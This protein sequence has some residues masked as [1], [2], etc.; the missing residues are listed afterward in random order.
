MGE[1]VA[2]AVYLFR[3]LDALHG[4]HGYAHSAAFAVLGIDD[5]LSFK[6]HNISVIGLIFF[7][8]VLFFDACKVTNKKH[9]ITTF[10]EKYFTHCFMRL[11]DST[12]FFST[13]QSMRQALAHFVTPPFQYLYDTYMTP[14]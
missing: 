6:C 10:G 8:F 12:L 5:Y 4:A 1:V 11:I 2:L 3:Q 14:I 7:V 13:I 9:Y